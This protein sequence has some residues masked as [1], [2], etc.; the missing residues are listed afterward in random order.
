MQFVGL[1]VVNGNLFSLEFDN[2][3]LCTVMSSGGHVSTSV[4]LSS[5]YEASPVCR[6]IPFSSF[7]IQNVFNNSNL[8]A[9]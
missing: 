5:L 8:T 9:F 4:I 6:H 7:N 1:H 2:L 3:H